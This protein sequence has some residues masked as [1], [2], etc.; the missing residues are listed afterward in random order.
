[1]ASIE[2]PIQPAQIMGPA[3]EPERNV[4]ATQNQSRIL[5]VDDDSAVRETLMLLLDRAGYSTAG[6]QSAFEALEQMKGAAPDVLLCDLEM[7][8]MSGFEFLSIVRSRFP[9]IAVIAMSGAFGDLPEAV[10]ADAFYSKGQKKPSDLFRMVATVLAPGAPASHRQ[11]RPVVWSH[12]ISRDSHGKSFV[13]VSCTECLR[14]FPVA[15]NVSLGRQIRAADCAFCGSE[16]RYVAEQYSADQNFSA[17]FSA[18][19]VPSLLTHNNPQQ[20][21]TR[22]GRCDS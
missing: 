9:Q 11:E 20:P 15:M 4:P 3:Q 12:W 22:T 10:L 2:Q 18:V 1:M 16:V 19:L 6:A 8:N 14:P 13:L 17:V 21:P 7:P 5:V